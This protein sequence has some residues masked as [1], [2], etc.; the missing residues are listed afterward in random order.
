LRNCLLERKLPGVLA[1]NMNAK[2][3]QHVRIIRDPRQCGR[4]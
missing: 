3:T 4:I 1:T 2:E